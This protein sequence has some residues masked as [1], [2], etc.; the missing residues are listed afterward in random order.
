MGIM[1]VK[2]K[3]ALSDYFNFSDFRDSQEKIIRRIC[4]GEDILVV[5]PTGVGKSL[6]YQLPAL[7]RDGYTLVI[8]PLISLIGSNSLIGKL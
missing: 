4:D 6:C 5:M 3:N 8:S 1:T 2:L 7:I